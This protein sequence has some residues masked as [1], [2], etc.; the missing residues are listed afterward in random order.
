MVRVYIETL[1]KVRRSTGLAE[2]ST[3]VM[4][5]TIPEKFF[6][7]P[8]GVD[9]EREPKGEREEE[10]LQQIG[11]QNGSICFGENRQWRGQ[12]DDYL[13]VCPNDHPNVHCSPD[14]TS[15]R[16]PPALQKDMLQRSEVV[17]PAQ[18]P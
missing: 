16:T 3:K 12:P 17:A 1:N 15:S 13:S 9:D 5:A 11:A 8:S 7:A 2:K 6:L 14:R 4:L 10:K 18:A